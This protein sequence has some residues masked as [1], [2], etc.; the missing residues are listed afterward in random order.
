[1][2]HWLIVLFMSKAS[3]G[4]DAGTYYTYFQWLLAAVVFAQIP[5]GLIIDLF[6]S[7]RKAL[8]WGGALIAVGYFILAADTTVTTVAAGLCCI[9]GS[10]L[11]GSSSISL[12]GSFYSGRTEYLDAGMCRYIALV[13]AGAFVASLFTVYA[14]TVLSWQQGCMVAGILMMS[15]HVYL[16]AV[17]K[18]FNEPK[19]KPR[20]DRPR[21]NGTLQLLI[22]GAVMIGFVCFCFALQSGY[23]LLSSVIS[24]SGGHPAMSKAG[25]FAVTAGV[26]VALVIGG[27]VLTR[28]PGKVLVRLGFGLIVGMAIIIPTPFY[29]N[30]D[31]A[32]LSDFGTI[33]ISLFLIIGVAVAEFLALPPLYAFIL[34]LK[35]KLLHTLLGTVAFAI[36]LPYLIAVSDRDAGTPMLA[37]IAVMVCGTAALVALRFKNEVDI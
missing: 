15:G 25:T 21:R 16:L 36:H 27:E 20:E 14:A 6:Y 2:R 28:R 13:N 4:G 24:V 30:A 7:R 32:T 22:L 1:M 19:L 12:L 9:V 31:A 11:Y 18:V 23:G 8:V 17:S 10:G 5:G 35:P 29:S 34:R 26:I 33:G 37:A 3:G